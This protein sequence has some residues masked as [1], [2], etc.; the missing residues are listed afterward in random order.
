VTA[1]CDRKWRQE[2]ATGSGDRK[3]RAENAE[4]V[5]KKMN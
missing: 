3:W 4:I 5:A 2:V 1:K